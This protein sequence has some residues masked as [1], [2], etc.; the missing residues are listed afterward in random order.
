MGMSPILLNVSTILAGYWWW[1][2]PRRRGGRRLEH[3]CRGGRVALWRRSIGAIMRLRWG[4][5]KPCRVSP[6][7]RLGLGVWRGGNI[8]LLTHPTVIRFSFQ[9]GT[10]KG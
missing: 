9:S 8:T 3:T 5:P 1:R 6:H 7:S 10:K 4:V 2:H